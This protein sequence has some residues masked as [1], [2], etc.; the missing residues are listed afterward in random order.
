M[1]WRQCQSVQ[2][3]HVCNISANKLPQFKKKKKEELGF[4]KEK[5]ELSGSNCHDAGT[6]PVLPGGLGL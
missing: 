6:A 3:E 4:K 1:S 2:F 5:S